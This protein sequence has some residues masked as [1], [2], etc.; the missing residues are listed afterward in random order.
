[1]AFK[2][3][4]LDGG[5]PELLHIRNKRSYVQSLLESIIKKDIKQ[6]FR[7]RNAE[8]LQNIANHLLNNNCQEVNYKDIAELFGLGSSITVAKY[9][10]CLK[11]AFLIGLLK[12]HSFKSKERIR[13]QKSYAVDTG[14]IANRD[15]SLLSQNMG[16]RLE[17]AVYLELLRRSSRNFN[18]I[19]YYKPSTLSKEVD[20]VVCSQGNAVELVQ[21]SYDISDVKTFR[22]E[23]SALVT[24]S[25]KLKCD[26]LTL[27][28]YDE[29]RNVE[30]GGKTIHVRSAIDWMLNR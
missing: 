3:Y 9:V 6:R 11:Q 27:V 18:D 26:N 15:E 29:S 19:Y 12:K 24:A 4:L 22:R 8:V 2:D 13:N 20:F 10:D 16:W 25:E 21:V 17:N 30:V 7:I 14:F 23:A 1:M 28:T 5:F